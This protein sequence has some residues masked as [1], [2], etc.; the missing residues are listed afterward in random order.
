L[1]SNGYN[2]NKFAEEIQS[3]WSHQDFADVSAKELPN[4][5][6]Q[7][8][9]LNRLAD[10]TKTVVQIY[11]MNGFKAVYSSPNSEEIC[12]FTP[13]E[14]NNKG[15]LY[16]LTSLPMKEIMYY[17]RSSKF[18]NTELRKADSDNSLFLSQVINMSYKNKRGEKKKMVT[19]NTCLD[20]NHD[21]KQS[22]QLIMWQ[23]MTHRSRSNDFISRY[24]FNKDCYY[25]Y[26]SENGKFEKGDLLT[27][28]EIEIIVHTSQGL[29]TKE[30]SEL[31]FLSPHT[32]D[33]HKKN[34]MNKLHVKTMGDV[35]EISRY[36]SLIQ[37]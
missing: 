29:S 25:T 19:T 14:L 31:L 18:V 27:P 1:E 6:T 4:I 37:G 8:H 15:F 30:T 24:R 11:D 23:D 20:T 5:L 9:I 10:T 17:I 35:I 16:W 26:C 33:N 36:L 32:V 34:I 12:G 7:N 28:R 13:Q 2:T 3:W 21:G 22:Y